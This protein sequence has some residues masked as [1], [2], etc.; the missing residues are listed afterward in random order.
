[1]NSIEFMNTYLIASL[2][3]INFLFFYAI[4]KR[5][6]ANFLLIP[7]TSLEKFLYVFTNVFI[8]V[9][10]FSFMLFVS[11]EMSSRLLFSVSSEWFVFDYNSNIRIILMTSILFF[12]QFVRFI[13]WGNFQIIFV[14]PTIILIGL[15]TYFDN[16]FIE[17]FAQYTPIR[18]LLY[19]L[20][21]VGFIGAA[22]LQFLKCEATFQT[23]STVLK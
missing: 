5:G 20:L 17:H 11:G 4:G 12:V 16:Y 19:A 22:Y 13:K 8:G 2:I 14:L 6:I 15:S 21:S 1:M 10:A 23:K 3:T 9:I 7:A 18:L